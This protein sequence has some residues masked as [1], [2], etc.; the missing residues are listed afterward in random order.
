VSEPNNYDTPQQVSGLTGITAIAAGDS[1]NV[2]VSSTGGGDAVGYNNDGQ[3]GNGNTTNESTPAVVTGIAGIRALAATSYTY[4]GDGQRV[5]R[6]VAGVTNHYA[7]DEDTSAPVMLS[8]GSENYIYDDAGNPIEEIESDG[9][10]LYYHHDSQG[11]TRVL[12]NSTGAVA[13]T[14]SYGAY[15]SLDSETGVT[16]TPLKW[17]GQAWDPSDHLYY[18]QNRYYDSNTDAFLTVDPLEADTGQPYEY[19]NDNP[20]NDADPSG[21][22]L[23]SMDTADAA[24]TVAWC[25]EYASACAASS[26][27]PGDFA[28]ALLTIVAPEDIAGDVLDGADAADAGTD[29][30]TAD[31]ASPGAENPSCLLATE[32]AAGEFAPIAGG[33][34][35]IGDK[36]AGQMA[37]RGWTEDSL[38]D[39]LENPTETHDVWDYTGGSG[40]EPATAYVNSDGAYAVVNDQTGNVVQISD[41]N[42][43]GWKPVWNDPRFQR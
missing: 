10:V 13:A 22:Q 21:E 27:T 3:L 8:D 28:A 33:G 23:A 25:N 20:I 43:P 35:S 39:A 26:P 42:D 24:K 34:L 32:D 1:H 29:A 12:T 9:T 11:S 5:S 41:A 37:A 30:T 2:F 38:Y 36:I 40:R 17:D 7:W 31:D 14:F 4:D 6:T 19:A 15:G 16:N 18:L